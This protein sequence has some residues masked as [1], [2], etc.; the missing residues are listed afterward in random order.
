MTTRALN[1][2]ND[3]FLSVN[4][5][6]IN[7]EAEQVAQAVRSR[8]L[9]YQGEWF[10]DLTAGIPYFQQ[11][12]QK[13]AQIA[14]AESVIKS[15]I[16]KTKGLNSLTSFSSNFDRQTRQFSVS[17]TANTIYGEIDQELSIST[18]PCNTNQSPVYD[19]F[20]IYN[21]DEY[22]VDV[23]GNFLEFIG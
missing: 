20:F 3:I 17:F 22:L 23:N 13:P 12:F 2:C 4:R 10:L 18:I 16:L 11:I 6:A 21:D 15:E 5:I 1:E 8:L 9:F 7:T 19:N 14:T